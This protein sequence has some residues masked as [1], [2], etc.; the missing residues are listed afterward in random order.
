MSI[1]RA[2][3]DGKNRKQIILQEGGTGTSQLLFVRNCP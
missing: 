1:K 2:D 3:F